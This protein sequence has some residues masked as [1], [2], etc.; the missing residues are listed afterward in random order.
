MLSARHLLSPEDLRRHKERLRNLRWESVE[1]QHKKGA[2]EAA[3]KA[4]AL[5]LQRAYEQRSDCSSRVP[6]HH[7]ETNKLQRYEACRVCRSAWSFTACVAYLA[8]DRREEIRRRY[9]WRSLL[10]PS[11]RAQS[12]SACYCAQRNS[13]LTPQRWTSSRTGAASATSRSGRAFFQLGLGIFPGC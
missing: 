7:V 10:H 1:R 13:R 4:A 5:S 2:V 11:V 3:Q 6:E 8:R 12:S 9:D